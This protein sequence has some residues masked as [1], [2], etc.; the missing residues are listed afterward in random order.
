MYNKVITIKLCCCLADQI[1]MNIFSSFSTTLPE[2]LNRFVAKYAE[3]WHD[4]WGYESIQ[5]GWTFG[6]ATS[7]KQHPMLKAYS[8]LSSKVCHI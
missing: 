4:T 2:E 8:S 3:Q 5:D 7:K 1:L 6:Q